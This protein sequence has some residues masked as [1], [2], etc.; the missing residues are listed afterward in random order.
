MGENKF[1]GKKALEGGIR[2]LAQQNIQ[3]VKKVQEIQYSN[4]KIKN[5]QFKQL[6]SNTIK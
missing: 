6:F 5:K 2:N 3:R 1:M 4:L